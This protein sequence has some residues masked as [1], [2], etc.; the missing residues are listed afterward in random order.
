[1]TIDPRSFNLLHVEDRLWIVTAPIGRSTYDY[2]F[3]R[4]F[5]CRHAT[6]L[7][8]RVPAVARMGAA[9]DYPQRFA[10]LLELGIEL[11]HSP[12]DYDKTSYLPNWYP[13]IADLTPKSIWYST[14]PTAD[15]VEEQFA[16][17]VFMKG[18]RQTSHH[19][20]EL[21]IV[22]DREHFQR[23]L[24][25]WRR[26]RILHWQRMVVRE[27]IPLRPV[28]DIATRGIPKSYE[29]RCFAWRGRC[30]SM[31]RY[32]TSEAY[33]LTAQ[34]EAEVT[35]LVNEVASR[36]NVVFLVVDVALSCAGRWI[37]VECNDGQDSGYAGN[38]PLILWRRILDCEGL[39]GR[40][41]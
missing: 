7:E 8:G 19:E 23:V 1:V 24:E 3:E 22:R 38:N 6:F 15:E 33:E 9:P 18:E 28:T 30:V 29:F 40:A 35:A 13:F 26:D 37:V 21:A 39:D 4:H 11:V 31:G 17:P 34:E 36:L 12:E 32:W 25:A 20:G 16:W 10:E 41:T 5:A 2:E 27:F 14:P